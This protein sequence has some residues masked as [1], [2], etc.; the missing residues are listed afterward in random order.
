MSV[1]YRNPQSE[2]LDVE[3][4]DLKNDPNEN[5]NLSKLPKHAGLVGKLTTR[6]LE[7]VMKGKK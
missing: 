1:D 5:T 7:H 2:P 4:Y 3:L 6:L